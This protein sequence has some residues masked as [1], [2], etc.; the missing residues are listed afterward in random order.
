MGYRQDKNTRGLCVVAGDQDAWNQL[1]LTRLHI[2]GH[3]RVPRVDPGRRGK[4]LIIL[5]AHKRPTDPALQ[6]GASNAEPG[7][8]DLGPPLPVPVEGRLQ[9]RK[10]GLSETMQ[11]PSMQLVVI[12]TVGSRNLI[13]K[14]KGDGHVEQIPIDEVKYQGTWRSATL[15][16]LNT[17]VL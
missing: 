13:V 4:Q 9:P 17:D 1:R 8:V 12:T 14:F 11:S 15:T 7:R 10:T 16:H 6:V 5:A 2:A 3:K